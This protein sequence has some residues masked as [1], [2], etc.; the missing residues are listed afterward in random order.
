MH[1]NIRFVDLNRHDI[2]KKNKK[3]FFKYIIGIQ[4]FEEIYYPTEDWEEIVGIYFEIR[5]N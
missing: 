5:L 4:V 2:Q 3:L 1:N